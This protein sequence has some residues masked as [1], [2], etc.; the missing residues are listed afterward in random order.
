MLRL[1]HIETSQLVCHGNTQ[2]GFYMMGTI[3]LHGLNM[4]YEFS[5]C[6]SLL[7]TETL[8]GGVSR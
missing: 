3:T 8:L 2:T 5:L 1:Y 4:M 7:I 6:Q